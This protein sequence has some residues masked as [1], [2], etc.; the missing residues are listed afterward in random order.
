MIYEVSFAKICSII[1]AADAIT[2]PKG[3]LYERN[4]PAYRAARAEQ[5]AASDKAIRLALAVLRE[6]DETDRMTRR[7]IVEGMINE[8]RAKKKRD[9]ETGYPQG[10]HARSARAARNITFLRLAAFRYALIAHQKTGCD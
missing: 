5:Q 7:T 1:E 9:R 3:R 8:Y 6:G 4:R 2:L 10:V